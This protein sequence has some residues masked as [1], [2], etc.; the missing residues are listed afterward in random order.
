MHHTRSTPRS[1]RNTQLTQHP[2]STPRSTSRSTPRSTPRSMHMI[3][4]TAPPLSL[5]TST[6]LLNE[7]NSYSHKF[8]TVEWNQFQFSSPTRKFRWLW[9]CWTCCILIS[10]LIS[11]TFLHSFNI[12]SHSLW[13]HSHITIIIEY[14][15]FDLNACIGVKEEEW[16]S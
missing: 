15:K 7:S 14:Y 12:Q 8:M 13:I 3:M 4:L 2:R 16:E 5:R 10:F 11:T 6:S 9:L 1:T